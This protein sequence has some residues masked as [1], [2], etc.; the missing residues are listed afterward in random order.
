MNRLCI[1]NEPRIA[2]SAIRFTDL[3]Q[4]YPE[5]AL[6]RAKSQRTEDLKLNQSPRSLSRRATDF[7]FCYAG[8]VVNFEASSFCF[9]LG[10]LNPLHLAVKFLACDE[11][12]G[13]E[14]DRH[15]QNEG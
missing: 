10:C 8:S 2:T 1:R 9:R 11:R 13:F 5:A 12:V 15:V 7:A 4:G 3:L 14:N 6:A